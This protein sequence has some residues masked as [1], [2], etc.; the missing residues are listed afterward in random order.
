[1]RSTTLRL[2]HQGP[3]E[4]AGVPERAQRWVATKLR[5]RLAGDGAELEV[6]TVFADG[7]YKTMVVQYTPAP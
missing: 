3:W 4:S 6:L 1:M 5:Q 2:P 7:P